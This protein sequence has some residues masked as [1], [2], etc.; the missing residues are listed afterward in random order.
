MQGIL[1]GL[2]VCMQGQRRDCRHV[3]DV[4]SD[5]A[6]LS[7]SEREKKKENIIGC[8][9]NKS[10]TTYVFIQEQTQQHCDCFSAATDSLRYSVDIS[11]ISK[12]FS[13]AAGA[14]ICLHWKRS[15][16][17]PQKSSG[18]ADSPHRI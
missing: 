7:S 8:F 1:Q 13:S 10:K 17:E 4:A 11:C 6:T 14:A 9:F 2:S 12:A 3:T 16:T 18:S 15:A 5:Q